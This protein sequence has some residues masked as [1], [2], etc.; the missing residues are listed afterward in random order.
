M[1]SLDEALAI[2]SQI[3]AETGGANGVRD[4]GGLEAALARPHATFGGDDL[5]PD[6]ISKAA[7]IAESI[8]KNH[9]FVDG[10]KRTGYILMRLTLIT[11]GLDV[12]ASDDD[13]YDLVIAI[14]TGKMDVDA[15][16]EWLSTH[17][18]SA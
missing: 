8:I 16:K 12:V 14:A 5:Y 13:E 3:V 1:I 11:Y 6:P 17:V 2:H 10:N 4:Q 18:K 9:P 7:A 15:I